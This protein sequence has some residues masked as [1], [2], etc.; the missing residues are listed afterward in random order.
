M[1]VNHHISSTAQ[2]AFTED[3]CP[4]QMRRESQG[5]THHHRHQGG[6]D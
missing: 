1:K 3:P 4:Q 2:E 6:S 5:L